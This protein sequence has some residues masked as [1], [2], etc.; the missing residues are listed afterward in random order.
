MPFSFFKKAI[1]LP[2]RE[3]LPDAQL[4][5]CAF[6]DMDCFAVLYERYVQRI[7]RY[8]LVR[9][10]TQDEAEDLTAATFLSAWQALPDFRGQS[11]FS[12]WLFT[13]ARHKVIDYYRQRKTQVL[14]NDTELWVDSNFLEQMETTERLTELRRVLRSLSVEEQELLTLRYAGS[15]NFEEIAEYFNR[16]PDAL[17][18]TFYRLLAK[19]KQ[20][21]EDDNE[22]KN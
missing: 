11:C 3:F 2:S 18:K 15:L 9:V 21:L 12:T 6:R 14:L 4:V 13:I 8:F 10:T 1:Q 5:K 7:Y 17:K 22:S 16:R 19:I 20:R